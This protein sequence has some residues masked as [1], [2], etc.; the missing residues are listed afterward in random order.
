MFFFFFYLFIFFFFSIFPTQMHRDANLT[1]H[2]KV[3]CQ[4]KIIIWTNLVDVESPMHISKLSH[5][6]FLVL[7]KKCF[8]IYGHEGHLNKW[9]VTI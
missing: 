5:K 2:K 6:A 8:T 1:L 7:E 4:P 3:N 9:T